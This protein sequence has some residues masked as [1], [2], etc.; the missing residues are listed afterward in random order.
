MKY[1]LKDLSVAT[2]AA[3]CIYTVVEQEIGYVSLGQVNDWRVE[4]R[5]F[6]LKSCQENSRVIV[7]S[8]R[9]ERPNQY[10][11][12]LRPDLELDATHFSEGKGLYCIPK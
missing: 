2:I 4:S 8:L 11:E 10:W 7:N 5:H 12:E 6:T 1:S 3:F 9:G